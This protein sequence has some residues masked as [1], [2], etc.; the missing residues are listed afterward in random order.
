[1]G[2][3]LVASNER[4]VVVFKSK[5]NRNNIKVNFQFEMLTKQKREN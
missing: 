4:R 5:E 2:T 1:M 3:L